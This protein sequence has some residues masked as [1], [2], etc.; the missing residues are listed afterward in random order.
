M[1]PA[2]SRPEPHTRLWFPAGR[3]ATGP[4]RRS[5]RFLHLSTPAVSYHRG[6]VRQLLTPVASLPVLGFH[7]VRRP[8][9]SQLHNGSKPSSY[10][11]TADVFAVRGF[12]T[13]ITPTDARLA[14]CQTGNLHGDL[15]QI[16]RATRLI[17]AYKRLQFGWRNLPTY[18]HHTRMETEFSGTLEPPPS[19]RSRPI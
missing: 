10:H 2:D 13:R 7:I 17:L 14:T 4:L 11:V 9:T 6:G 12:G 8:A 16:T 3:C 18:G 1:S 19:F 5:P 15:P